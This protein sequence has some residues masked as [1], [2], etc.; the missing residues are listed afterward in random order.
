MGIFANYVG[1][2]ASARITSIRLDLPDKSPLNLTPCLP[3]LR[4]EK[5]NERYLSKRLPR[6]YILKRLKKS[7]C[8]QIAQ[9]LLSIDAFDKP[10]LYQIEH[11][12]EVLRPHPNG[13]GLNQT[14]GRRPK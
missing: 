1:L 10:M 5:R 2:L 8:N 3:A 11:T 6:R 7:D 9:I 4:T 14:P 13:S 12:L